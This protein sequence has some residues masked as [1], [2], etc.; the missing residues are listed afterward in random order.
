MRKRREPPSG[1]AHGMAVL[2]ED[3]VRGIRR[4]YTGAYGELTKYARRFG[5]TPTAIYN[6]VNRVTWKDAS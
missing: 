6:I 3:D 1:S 5:V 4:N 2:T